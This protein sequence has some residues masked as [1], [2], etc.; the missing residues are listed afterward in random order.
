MPVTEI[1]ILVPHLT[2]PKNSAMASVRRKTQVLN[3]GAYE[4]NSKNKFR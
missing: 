4:Y 3:L 2:P 1:Y